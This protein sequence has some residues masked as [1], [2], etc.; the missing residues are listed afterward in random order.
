MG[1]AIVGP[2]KGE[3]LLWVRRFCVLGGR[4]CVM[5]QK[6]LCHRWGNNILL[7]GRYCIIGDEI[8]CHEW[9]DNELL[10]GW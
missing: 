4:Y 3:N 1:G 10:V 9:G 8:L 2:R 5:S 7:R 6:I